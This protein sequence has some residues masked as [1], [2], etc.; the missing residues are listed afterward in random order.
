M[1]KPQC[2]V[3][4]SLPEHKLTYDVLSEIFIKL[5]NGEL[6]D[7]VSSLPPNN[8]NTDDVYIFMT[9]GM[10]DSANR[11][12]ESCF[13]DN[14]NF[15]NTGRNWS[16]KGYDPKIRK[17]YFRIPHDA[18]DNGV[19][20]YEFKKNAF[21]RQADLEKKEHP[22]IIHYFGIKSGVPTKVNRRVLPE[23][24]RDIKIALESGKFKLSLID[25]AVGG[26]DAL[27][28]HCDTDSRLFA[29]SVDSLSLR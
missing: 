6:K 9:T 10:K 16:P 15:V 17:L 2:V 25:I 3:Y 24:R 12:Q 29:E 7:K 1:S 28:L 27:C 14:Y 13:S 20:S 22:I 18:D 4:T 23:T 5:D 19:K 11:R 8:P 21:E 26:G